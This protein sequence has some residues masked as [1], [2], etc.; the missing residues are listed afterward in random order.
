M[1]VL[2]KIFWIRLCRSDMNQRLI[3]AKLTQIL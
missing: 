3:K 1:L 2:E